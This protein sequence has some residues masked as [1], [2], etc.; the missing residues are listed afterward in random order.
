MVVWKVQLDVDG[1]IV[2]VSNCECDEASCRVSNVF[3]WQSIRYLWLNYHTVHHM[4]PHT[5]MSHHPAIQKIM[6]ETAKQF[7]IKY[8]CP[9]PFKSM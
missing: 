1:C 9:Y 8:N 5:D 4:F 3:V 6:V 2:Y 7:G